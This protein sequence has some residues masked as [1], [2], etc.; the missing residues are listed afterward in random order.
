M[1]R[2]ASRP[3]RPRASPSVEGPPLAEAGERVGRYEVEALLDAPDT[4]SAEGLRDR[5][6]LE[7]LYAT[8]LRV[9]ELVGLRLSDIDLEAGFRNCLRA[10]FDFRLALLV[11]ALY[12]G[13]LGPDLV[14]RPY[15][16]V[17]PIQGGWQEW[18]AKGLRLDQ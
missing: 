18:Q 8:G 1:R 12:R 15:L 14:F 17:P 7:V 2:K 11:R 6:M 16:G 3:V 10:G 5:S 13:E 9:S 4:E